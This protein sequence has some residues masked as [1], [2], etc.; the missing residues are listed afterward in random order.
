[1]RLPRWWEAASGRIPTAS[2]STIRQAREGA[3]SSSNHHQHLFLFSFF[4]SS[5]SYYKKLLRKRHG[6]PLGTSAFSFYLN[7]LHREMKSAF[8]CFFFLWLT[9]MRYLVKTL[10][11]MFICTMIGRV[12]VLQQIYTKNYKTCMK[13]SPPPATKKKRKKKTKWLKWA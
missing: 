8:L 13:P 5:S 7:A 3:R 12:G 9:Q 11:P 1:M 4:F 10:I 6:V 2:G